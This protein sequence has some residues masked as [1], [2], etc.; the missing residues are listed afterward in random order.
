SYMP[1]VACQC[2]QHKTAAFERLSGV[3]R[4]RREQALNREEGCMAGMKKE[5]ARRAGVS[6]NDR[7]AEK[8]ANHARMMGG[9]LFWMKS[10]TFSIFVRLATRSGKSFTA[11][12]GIGWKISLSSRWARILLCDVVRRRSP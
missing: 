6:E 4:G 7:R 10:P 5:E 11:G 1:P 9:F 3:V 2:R 8:N 12:F